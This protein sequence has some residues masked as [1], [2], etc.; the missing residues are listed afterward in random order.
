MFVDLPKGTST[1]FVDSSKGIST[2]KNRQNS[3]VHWLLDPPQGVSA[4][5]NQRNG[6]NRWFNCLITLYVERNCS[7]RNVHIELR[8]DSRNMADKKQPSL[9]F[10][11][12]ISSSSKAEFESILA[13][14]FK[15]NKRIESQP[16][17]AP[18]RPFMVRKFKLPKQS[19]APFVARKI[20]SA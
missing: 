15:S 8:H 12:F 7:H 20:Q 4:I 11:Y 6:P 1:T 17:R 16:C 14:I 3:L 19:R 18:I 10:I 9:K 2:T 13:R 5:K